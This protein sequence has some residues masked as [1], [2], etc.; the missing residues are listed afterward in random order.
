PKEAPSFFFAIEGA[1]DC[2]Y[3]EARQR[4][5]V[6]CPSEPVIVDTKERKILESLHL[7]G[8]L[9]GCDIAPDFK[10]VAIDPSKAQFIYR[11][12]LNWTKFEKMEVSQIKF[13]ASSSETGVYGICV[14]SDNSV[15]FSMTYD[16][17]GP[18]KLRRLSPDNKVTVVGRIN[19]NSVLTASAG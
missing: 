18:V 5:Y 9:Q 8:T 1:K 17:S 15:L 16:G 10:F 3:D 12:G 19:M 11:V 4:L 6:T 2:A 7:N 14:G 13:P